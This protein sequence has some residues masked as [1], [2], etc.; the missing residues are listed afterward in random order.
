MLTL[1]GDWAGW[2]F[3][4]GVAAVADSAVKLL[5]STPLQGIEVRGISQPFFLTLQSGV[6]RF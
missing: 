5:H 1:V 3:S 6:V 2:E 4:A